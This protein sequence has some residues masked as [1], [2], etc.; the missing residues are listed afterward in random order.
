MSESEGPRYRGLDDAV[1]VPVRGGGRAYPCRTCGALY[2]EK[3]ARDI[4]EQ[5]CR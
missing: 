4:H 2:L 5:S 3:R 1:T